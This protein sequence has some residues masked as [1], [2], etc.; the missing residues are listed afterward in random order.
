MVMEYL[1]IL[2]SKSN[3]CIKLLEESW[4]INNQLNSENY[5]S[6]FRRI[7]Q[8]QIAGLSEPHVESSPLY[9]PA[10]HSE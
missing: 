7:C 9:D 1:S 6:L 8:V 10:P 4:I 5:N 3:M 2:S